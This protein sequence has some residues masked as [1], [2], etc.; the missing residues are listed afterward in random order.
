MGGSRA[1]RRKA[2]GLETLAT[3]SVFSKGIGGRLNALL[4]KNFACLAK[5]IQAD[6]RRSFKLDWDCP[7][8]GKAGEPQHMVLQF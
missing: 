8:M 6:S 7:W 1:D 4:Q 2:H 5:I 3:E